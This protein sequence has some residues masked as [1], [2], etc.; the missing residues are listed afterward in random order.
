ME[1]KIAYDNKL[2]IV[3]H[4]FKNQMHIYKFNF[5]DI[6]KERIKLT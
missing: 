6:A 3:K 2:R 5:N 1:K 4:F